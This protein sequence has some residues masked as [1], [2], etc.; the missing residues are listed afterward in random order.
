LAERVT[1]A[2][3][4]SEMLPAVAQGAIGIEIRADDVQTAAEIAPLDHQPTALCVTAERRFLARLEGS[5]RTPIA[6]LAEI[7][8]DNI[9]FRGMILSPDGPRCFAE[10]RSGLPQ[11]AVQLADE[12]SSEL[13]A[14]AGPGFLTSTT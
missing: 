4:T 10:E 8:D 2:M 14:A 1:K 13:L 7:R 9:V 6:G 12:V 5:C 11:L 3:P